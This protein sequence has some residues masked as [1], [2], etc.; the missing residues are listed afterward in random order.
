MKLKQGNQ[1]F[2]KQA[3]IIEHELRRR[4]WKH[5]VLIDILIDYIICDCIIIF[6]CIFD[7]IICDYIFD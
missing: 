5:E 6:D 4:I 3:R 2:K 1:N 7:Y